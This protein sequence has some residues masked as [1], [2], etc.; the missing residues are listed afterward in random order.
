MEQLYE[1]FRQ[2]KIKSNLSQHTAI[3]LLCCFDEHAEKTDAV[4]MEASTL[5]DVEVRRNLSL[6]TVRHYSPGV[7]QH[8]TNGRE[9]VLEQRTEET[10]QMVLINN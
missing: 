6:L 8:L 9:V 1:I 5:F 2:A 4:A 10:S 7:I 3:S